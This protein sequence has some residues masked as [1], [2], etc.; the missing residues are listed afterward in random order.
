MTQERL[1][2]IITT[3]FGV[4]PNNKSRT[5]DN[6]KI[7]CIYHKILRENLKFKYQYIADMFGLTHASIIHSVKNFDVMCKFDPKLKEDYDKVMYLLHNSEYD[8]EKT[9]EFNKVKYENIL[10]K[11]QKDD[12]NKCKYKSLRDLLETVPESEVSVVY[13]RMEAIIKM[14]IIKNK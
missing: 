1:E 13:D 12:Q 8:S 6:V 4:N 5:M 14:L 7:R 11:K 3:E 9:V 2:E 10:L